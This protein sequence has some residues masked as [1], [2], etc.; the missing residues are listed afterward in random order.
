MLP[1]LLLPMMITRPLHP[2]WQGLRSIQAAGSL[3]RQ[4][5]LYHVDLRHELPARMFDCK[6]Q[7]Q[8]TDKQ[9]TYTEQSYRITPTVDP[10]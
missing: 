9:N 10:A 1:L 5:S 2:I 3:H 7:T 4:I 8:C 6:G